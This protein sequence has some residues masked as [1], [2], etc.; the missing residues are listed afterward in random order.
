MNTFRHPART[1]DGTGCT[2]SDVLLLLAPTSCGLERR[3]LTDRSF[4]RCRHL[5][6][7]DDPQGTAIGRV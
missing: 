5:C 1:A 3:D 4:S 6:V 7:S 2:P